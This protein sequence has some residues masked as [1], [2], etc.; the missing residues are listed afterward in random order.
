MSNP[1]FPIFIAA[2]LIVLDAVWQ[3]LTMPQVVIHV[4]SQ[5]QE[6]QVQETGHINNTPRRLKQWSRLPLGA[7]MDPGNETESP[8]QGET[9]T[10]RQCPLVPHVALMPNGNAVA[11]RKGDKLLT[12]FSSE[13]FRF[14]IQEK[15]FA[16]RKEFRNPSHGPT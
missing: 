15:A 5:V 14:E 16:L 11:E 9:C 3:N 1:G 13:A 8:Q 2:L 4:A 7:L 12:R 6:S 10:A